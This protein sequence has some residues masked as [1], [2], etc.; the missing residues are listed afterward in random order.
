LKKGGEFLELME[1]Y[2]PY[3]SL[4]SGSGQAAKK[5]GEFFELVEKTTPA[6]P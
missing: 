4:E 1:I 3:T 6:P 5:G 2:C